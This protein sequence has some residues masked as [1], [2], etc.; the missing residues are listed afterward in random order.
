MIA[1]LICTV[2]IS[3][4][5]DFFSHP[6]LLLSS[7]KAGARAIVV[8][9]YTIWHLDLPTRGLGYG[10]ILNDPSPSSPVS[11]YNIFYFNFVAKCVFLEHILWPLVSVTRFEKIP[12]FARKAIFTHIMTT[13]PEPNNEILVQAHSFQND[14]QSLFVQIMSDNRFEI[15]SARHTWYTRGESISRVKYFKF[16]NRWRRGYDHFRIEWS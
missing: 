3:T 11:R 6:S 4:S 7:S 5:D 16:L 8:C 13:T 2:S 10:G 15:E 1:V 12:F 14:C 9:W